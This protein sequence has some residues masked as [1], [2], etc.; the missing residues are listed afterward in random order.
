MKLVRIKLKSK[1]LNETDNSSKDEY[2]EVLFL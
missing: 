2:V 1:S